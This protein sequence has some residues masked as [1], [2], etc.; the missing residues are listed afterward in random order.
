MA[1][2]TDSLAFFPEKVDRFS[3]FVSKT[4]YTLYR[5]ADHVIYKRTTSSPPSTSPRQN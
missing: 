4:L 5:E 1:A 3:K 2:Y